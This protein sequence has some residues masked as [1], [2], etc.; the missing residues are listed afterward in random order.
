MLIAGISHNLYGGS[1]SSLALLCGSHFI[2]ECLSRSTRNTTL[3]A[4]WRSI[5]VLLPVPSPDE[6][7]GFMFYLE[8]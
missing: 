8:K 6:G 1:D 4:G 5:C 3:A 7:G 2:W